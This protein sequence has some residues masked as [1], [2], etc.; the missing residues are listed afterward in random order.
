MV[1]L[2]SK[3]VQESLEKRMQRQRKS[4]VNMSCEEN[5]LTITRMRFGLFFRESCRFMGNQP[6]LDQIVDVILADHRP[7]PVAWIQ[8]RGRPDLD[9]D[10][11]RLDLFPFAFVVAF[12]ACSK[13]TIF[14]FLMVAGEARTEQRT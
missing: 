2:C 3:E 6:P 5:A 8:P 9:E 10:P 1:K 4:T 14:S 13:A 11:P 12:F 7:D